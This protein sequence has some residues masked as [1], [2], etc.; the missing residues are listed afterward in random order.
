MKKK[1]NLLLSFFFLSFFVISCASNPHS[2]IVAQK[3]LLSKESDR[4]FWK[5]SGTDKKGNP[6][7]VYIQGTVHLGNDRIFPVSENVLN[8]FNKANRVFAEISS[9]DMI[10]AMSLTIRVMKE[11]FQRDGRLVTDSLS[12]KQNEVLKKYTNPVL[13]KKFNM[14]EPWV[15]LMSIETSIFFDY[16]VDEK[17]GL[18]NVFYGLA[19]EQG[20]EVGGLDSLETQMNLFRYKDYETQL[21]LL[22]DI[23]D[24]VDEAIVQFQNLYEAYVHDDI[25]KMKTIMNENEQKDKQKNQLYVEYN[26]KV[27]LDRNESWAKQITHFLEE[28]GSTFI[29]VGAGHLIEGKTL[30]DFLRE[31]GT[32]E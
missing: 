16:G 2:D 30:F 3:A 15:F 29:Y 17:H 14:F 9:E 20:R 13:L 7:D 22:K 26:K 32:I 10:K 6:S 12:E 21:F 5:I 24:N 27:L 25:E 18:D 23:L 28:G 8:Q 31:M 1:I 4:M 11:S 19:K